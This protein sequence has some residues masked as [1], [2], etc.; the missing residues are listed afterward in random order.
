MSGRKPEIEE[1][2]QDKAVED[3]LLEIPMQRGALYAFGAFALIVLVGVS[4]QLFLINVVHG[5]TYARSA[6]ANMTYEKTTAA[7]RG[8]IYD[9]HGEPLVTNRV[10]ADIFISLRTLPQDG[11]ELMK[12]LSSAGAILGLKPEDIITQIK[13]HDWRLGRL[14]IARDISHDELVELTAQNIPG[15]EISSGFTRVPV[16]PFAFSHVLGYVGLADEHDLNADENLSPEDEVGKSGLE[17]EYDSTLRGVKGITRTILDARQQAQGTSY[18][19]EPQQGQP[20]YT[21]IDKELQEYVYT[22]LSDQIKSLDAKGG[23]GIVLDA[24]GGAVRAL[25]SLPSFDVNDI[26]A[27]LSAADQPLF[28]RAVSGTYSPGST[29]KPLVALAALEEHVLSPAKQFFSSGALTVPNPYHPDQPSVFHDWKPQGWVDMRSAI[30]QSSDVYFYIVGGGYGDQTGLGIDRLRT[31]WQTFDLDKPT[32]IDLPS[33]GKGFLPSPVWQ[34]ASGGGI[35]RVGDTYHVTIGQGAF[36]VTPIELANYVSAIANG[37][38]LYVPRL[39]QEVPEKLLQ[40]IP[41][42]SDDLTV[43]QEGMRQAVTSPKGTAYLL[44]FLPFEVAAKTG[45]AQVGT[46]SLNA[47]TVGYAPYHDPKIVFMFMIEGAQEGGENVVPVA[48]DV[49]LWY[50]NNRIK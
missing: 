35:W 6:H 8:I 14:L 29:I 43:V 31:W 40:H 38:D 1:I 10:S 37:G 30:A 16:D 7:P 36:V 24:Q 3:E 9:E 42:Q 34:E 46:V 28:D 23:V 32:G 41:L 21:F 19:V 5:S 13:Q 49:L 45:S 39:N 20:L 2:L 25:V 50:Y 11:T 26:P 44:S 48:H 22:R 4:V 12:A 33:E 47:F 27:Y 15:F 18:R 17:A